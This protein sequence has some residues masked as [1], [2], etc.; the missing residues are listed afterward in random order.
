MTDYHLA[1]IN[2][3]RLIAPEGDPRVAEFTN[4][5]PR[6]NELAEQSPGF[7]WRYSGDYPDPL[8]AFNMSVWESVESLSEFAYRT[9]HVEMFRLRDRWFTPMDT[10]H[11]A[12]WWV[13]KGEVPSVEQG[14]GRLDLLD[15]HGPSGAAFTFKQRFAP[16]S[17]E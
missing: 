7:I 3:G 5:L 6:I 17:G 4:N 1:Q 9:A 16:P 15:A 10:N 8:V 12:L 2:I 14:M 13:L 11:M